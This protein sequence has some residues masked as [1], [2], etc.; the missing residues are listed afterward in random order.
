MLKNIQLSN[1][2]KFSTF[3]ISDLKR[4]NLIAGK[5]NTGKTSLLEA[6]FFHHD[7]TAPDALI[8]SFAWRGIRAMSAP[9]SVFAPHFHNYDTNVP[10]R[11]E[12]KTDDDIE[13]L[14]VILDADSRVKRVQIKEQDVA[15][16]KMSQPESGSDSVHQVGLR[17]V[18]FLNNTEINSAD[19]TLKVRRHG[20]TDMQMEFSTAPQ[21]VAPAVYLN[22]PAMNSGKADAERFGEMEILNET[23][24]LLRL[25]RIVSPEIRDITTIVQDSGS[26][27]FA[28]IGLKRKVP[29]NLLGGGTRHLLSIALAF[30]KAR[31]GS[32]LLDEI[33]AGLHYSVMPQVWK[34]IDEASAHYDCQV[35][36]T[37]HSYEIVR[38]AVKGLQDLLSPDFA[39]YRLDAESSKIHARRYDFDAIQHAVSDEIEIR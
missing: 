7:W 31:K 21:P 14:E 4:I 18:R 10:L 33:D 22:I 29:I 9:D 30:G 23:D 28:D 37:S 6:I 38:G 25:L 11:I 39:F 13:R 3:E 35:F 20:E 36:A 26:M 16:D 12:V 15:S 1:Y 19:L 24:E 34:W 2:K 27:L 8:K 5:N 32:L 17:V